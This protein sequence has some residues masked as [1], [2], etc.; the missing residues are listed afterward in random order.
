MT[1]SRTDTRPNDPFPGS[2]KETQLLLVALNPEA[3]GQS[4]RKSAKVRSS[5]EAAFGHMG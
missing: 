4:L 3:L 5:L 2:L 1:F